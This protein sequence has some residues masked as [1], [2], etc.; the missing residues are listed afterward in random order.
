M[1]ECIGVYIG[2]RVLELRE[3]R[4]LT[5]KE[6]AKASGVPQPNISRLERGVLDDINVSTLLGLASALRVKPQ[7]LLPERTPRPRR[8]R[9]APADAG[10]P[11]AAA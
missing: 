3:H 7:T 6:L 9:P 4:D 10:D 2:K 11:E 5:Q 8:T 1:E